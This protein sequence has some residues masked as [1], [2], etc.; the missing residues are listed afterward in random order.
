MAYHTPSKEPSRFGLGYVLVSVRLCRSRRGNTSEHSV[1]LA[2]IFGHEVAM[3]PAVERFTF[4]NLHSSCTE[5]F[6]RFV[7][8]T[9]RMFNLLLSIKN[10]PATQKDRLQIQG[11][12]LRENDAHHEFA[13]CRQKLL[14]LTINGDG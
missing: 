14:D 13:R 8:E 10:R 5:S 2:A 3:H 6:E 12:R 7:L 4:S 11:Q 9:R 1:L